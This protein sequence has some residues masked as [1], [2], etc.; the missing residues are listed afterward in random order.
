[1]AQ[2][3]RAGRQPASYAAPVRGV[4]VTDHFF[5]RLRETVRT[6]MLPYQW[7]KRLPVRRHLPNLP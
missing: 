5:G 7:E 2:K 3:G 1:M 4:S 6:R